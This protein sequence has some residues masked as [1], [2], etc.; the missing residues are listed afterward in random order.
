MIQMNPEIFRKPQTGTRNGRDGACGFTMIEVLIALLVLA[1]GLIGMASLQLTSV[2]T[3]HS[4]YLRSIASSIALD[5]EEQL[6]IEVANMNSDGC[7]NPAIVADRVQEIWSGRLGDDTW[8]THEIATLPGIGA[9]GSITAAVS[10][11]ADVT[12]EGTPFWVEIDFTLNWAE[13]RFEN[14]N[15]NEQFRFVGR[16]ACRPAPEIL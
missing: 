7:P 5:M 13:Q 10:A 3:A 8:A 15:D 16:V 12:P 6:W 4:S 11:A 14:E 9:D 2:K 1:I